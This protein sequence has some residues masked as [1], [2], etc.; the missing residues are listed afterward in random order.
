VTPKFVI[1]NRDGLFAQVID[2]EHLRWNCNPTVAT[3]MGPDTL[4]WAIKILTKDDRPEHD[5]LTVERVA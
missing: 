4:V 2:D 1:K 5:V 3:L